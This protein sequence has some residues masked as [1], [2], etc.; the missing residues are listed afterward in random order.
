M[1]KATV[2]CEKQTEFFLPNT[3]KFL[4]NAR[5]ILPNARSFLPNARIFLPNARK[6]QDSQ[7]SQESQGAP[8]LGFE[9]QPVRRTAGYQGFALGLRPHRGG[10]EEESG[11]AA[12]A[13]AAANVL[14]AALQNSPA[15]LGGF[16]FIRLD[17]FFL[18]AACLFISVSRET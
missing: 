12:A 18:S 11:R 4:P 3:P 16:Q 6:W 13:A 7:D 17:D 1:S 10:R 5:S 8:G 14:L 15:P 9:A 2:C